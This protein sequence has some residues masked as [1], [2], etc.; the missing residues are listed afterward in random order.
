VATA[1][2]TRE[3]GAGIFVWPHGLHI[4]VGGNI[5]AT[6]GTVSNTV[7]E[8]GKKLKPALEAGFGHHVFKFSPEGKV[9]M[10]LGTKGVAGEAPILF[11]V[12]ADVIVARNCD[13]FIADGHVG[14]PIAKFSEDG[15]F[16]KSWGTKGS[17]PG[18]R[19]SG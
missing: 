1:A 12:P 5:W 11:N 9:L 13:I 2:I 15:T 14:T 16:L 10:R 3:W 19:V 8:F 17:G 18:R 6:D 4:D 7:P